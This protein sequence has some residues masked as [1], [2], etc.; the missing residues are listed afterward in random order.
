MNC[1]IVYYS[2]SVLQQSVSKIEPKKETHEGTVYLMCFLTVISMIGK[3]H[4]NATV[5]NFKSIAKHL[6]VIAKFIVGSR[7]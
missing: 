1:V 2:F 4:F 3:Q 6:T 5:F 7:R